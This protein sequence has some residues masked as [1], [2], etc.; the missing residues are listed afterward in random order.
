MKKLVLGLALASAGA[1]GVACSAS[2][3][4]PG[5]DNTG[6]GNLDGVAILHAGTTVLAQSLADVANVQPDRVVFPASAYAQLASHA[7]GDVL[8]ADRQTPGTTGNNPDGFLRKV[9][10]VSQAAEGTV[11]MTDPAT[12]QEAVDLLKFQSTLQVPALTVDGPATQ[13]APGQ[14]HTQKSG[15]TTVKLLDFSGTKIFDYTGTASLPNNQTIGFN[16]FATVDTGTLDFSPSYDVGADLGFLKINSFHATATGKLDATL[17]IDAGVKLQTSLDSQTF[18][19]LVA[20]Q[21]LKSNSTTIADYKVSLGSLKLGPFNMPSSAHFTATLDCD[22][23]W[24]GGPEV[25][26][27]GT[28]S[29]SV[30]AGIKYENGTL[31][32]VFDKNA[33]FTQSGPDYTMDGMVR[34]YCSITPKFELQFFGVAMADLTAKAYAGAGGA[35]ACG[36]PDQQGNQQGLIHG[37][38]EAGLSASV[39]A[40]VDI[41]GLYKWEKECTLFDLNGEAQYDHAF[42]LPGGQNATCTPAS[43]YDLPPEPPAD[44]ASCFG[45]SSG[46]TDGGADGGGIINGTCTHDVCTA[47]DKLG[48][49]CDSCTMAVCAKDPYCCDTYWGLSCFQDVQQ[50]CGKTCQ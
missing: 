38:V 42:T 5:N 17:I 32:P 13:S 11:V 3:T 31:S 33:S 30:T 25:K 2:P 20:Q 28:A 18:T 46:D 47:G 1:L 21:L 39:H 8:L 41:F 45:S 43:N 48:Q 12:L 23:A 27:G 16:A 7:A 10:S 22:F 6:N 40:K 14:L 37:D 29:G 35:L 19:Q 34:A 44:P 24:G 36:G 49:Q 4:M 9:K 15:G 26:V 50:Y